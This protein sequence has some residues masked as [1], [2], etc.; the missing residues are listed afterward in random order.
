MG[1]DPIVLHRV[2][3]SMATVSIRSDHFTR[4]LTLLMRAYEKQRAN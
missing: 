1:S 2:T 3:V 4:F